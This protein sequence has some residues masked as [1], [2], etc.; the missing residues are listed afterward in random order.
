[1]YKW[2]DLVLGTDELNLGLAKRIF[3]FV[4][5]VLLQQHKL[6]WTVQSSYENVI[7]YS[8]YIA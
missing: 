5:L 4:I 3:S 7:Q 8:G 2:I 1:M 6:L